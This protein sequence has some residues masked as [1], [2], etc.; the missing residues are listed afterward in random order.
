MTSILWCLFVGI[1]QNLCLPDY[2]L[3]CWFFNV[4]PEGNNIIFNLIL[5]LTGEPV[6]CTD[7]S[8][9]DA[10]RVPPCQRVLPM[11]LAKVVDRG[12]I[13]FEYGIRSRCQALLRPLPT[14]LSYRLVTYFIGEFQCLR[15]L[16]QKHPRLAVDRSGYQ[17]RNLLL[18]LHHSLDRRFRESYHC[19]N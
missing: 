19:S 14:V 2:C 4:G 6:M 1:E 12:P 17:L 7:C 8:L 10:V 11:L 13:A 3:R 16:C 15:L 5:V 18:H 9:N